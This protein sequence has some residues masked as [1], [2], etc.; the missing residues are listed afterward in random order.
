VEK[1]TEDTYVAEFVS[2]T[3]Q[4]TEHLLLMFFEFSF[5]VRFLSGALAFIV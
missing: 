5:I 1:P 2:V 4:L 3:K